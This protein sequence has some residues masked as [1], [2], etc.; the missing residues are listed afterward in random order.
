MANLVVQNFQAALVSA[1]CE[2][3]LQHLDL[4]QD[5]QQHK[6]PSPNSSM[7]EIQPLSYQVADVFDNAVIID[8]SSKNIIVPYRLILQRLL[9]A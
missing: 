3:A 7:S 4:S 2:I 5:C 9:R 6:N 8:F 1:I